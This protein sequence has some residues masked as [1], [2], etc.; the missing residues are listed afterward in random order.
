MSIS[1]T[2]VQRAEIGFHEATEPLRA[3]VGCFWVV[4][5]ERDAVL[6]VVPD[7]STS[8]SIELQNDRPSG[9]FLRGP[10]ARPE[11]RRFSAPAQLIGIRLRPG[12]SFLLS[13]IPAHTII[14]RRFALGGIAAFRDL[15]SGDLHPLTPER[16]I[17]VLQRFLVQRLEHASL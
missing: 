5:A 10:L 8:I 4:T 13:G 15:V 17:E 14:G 12:V 11:E 9:W 16:C 7:G 3:F 6:R 2:L 1:S